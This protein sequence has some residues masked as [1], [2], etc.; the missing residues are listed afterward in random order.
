MDLIRR[1]KAK[2]GNN[3][4]ILSGKEFQSDISSVNNINGENDS[5]QQLLYYSNEELKKILD[6]I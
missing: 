5:T 2:L 3:N 4:S 1:Q 6:E